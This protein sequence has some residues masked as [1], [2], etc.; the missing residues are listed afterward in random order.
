MN[1]LLKGIFRYTL[2]IFG[3]F[4]MANGIILLINAQLGVSPW[5]VLHIG[6]ANITGFSLGRVLQGLGLLIVGI[7]YFLGIKPHIATLLN[8]YLIGYFVDQ[9]NLISYIPQPEM[10]LLR[11]I[12]CFLGVM[13]VG[14][15]TGFYIS[16][17]C[18]AGPRDG[19]MMAL[20]QITSF[21]IRKVRALI[22]FAVTIIGYFLDGPIGIGT[23][24]YAIFVGVFVEIGFSLIAY[25]KKSRLFIRLWAGHNVNVRRSED[26]FRQE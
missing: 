1:S 18:G 12:F 25:L 21:R 23:L 22:E 4:M 5:N 17:K 24:I 11:Y 10:L 15:G 3:L 6:L 14:L 9:I 20:G 2:I 26:C 13:S 7:S 8:M 16:A 19:L